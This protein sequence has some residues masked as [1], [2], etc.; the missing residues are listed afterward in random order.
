MTIEP[1]HVHD[2]RRGPLFPLDLTVGG[3]HA[4]EAVCISCWEYTQLPGPTDVPKWSTADHEEYAEEV[5]RRF[6]P[7]LDGML[8]GVIS[9]SAGGMRFDWL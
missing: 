3:R 6:G 8:L 4:A 9:D 7:L 1:G 2:W 5:E